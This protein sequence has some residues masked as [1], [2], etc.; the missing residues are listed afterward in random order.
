MARRKIIK[1]GKGTLTMSLPSSWV[2]QAKLAAGDEIEVE[3]NGYTLLV[4]PPLRMSKQEPLRFDLDCYS[5]GMTFGIL[6]NLYTRGE[7]EIIF[8]YHTTE[9]LQA[10][11]TGTRDLIGFHV[12][13]QTKNTCTVKELAQGTSEDFDALLRRILLLLLS[14]AEEGA[15]AY[16]EKNEEQLKILRTRDITINTLCAYCMRQLNKRA[17]TSIQH[18]LHLHTLLTLL[19]ELGDA[20]SRF[21]YDVI[22][23]GAKTTEL[24]EKTARF[25]RDYYELFYSFSPKKANDLRTKRDALRSKT[26]SLNVTSKQDIV[27][28]QHLRRILD[29]TMDIAKFNLAMQI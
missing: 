11:L 17:G 7:Q 3:Q 14:V 20:Y 12:I 1:Q 25:L 10:L 16:K 23:L 22:R 29:L 19:E 6:N 27:A 18:A 15:Q 26:E 4:S 13:E 8:T 21:Y 28:L 5:R 2:K 24:C 9:Q